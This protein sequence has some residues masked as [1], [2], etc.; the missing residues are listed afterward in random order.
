[1]T[2][3]EA[4]KCDYC[5]QVIK[6]KPLEQHIKEHHSKVFV[7]KEPADSYEPYKYRCSHLDTRTVGVSP[8][9]LTASQLQ[10]IIFGKEVLAGN[11]ALCANCFKVR[12]IYKLG[13]WP[14]LEKVE[15]YL[16]RW[17]RSLNGEEVKD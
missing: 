6:D 3:L 12:D 9:T 8:T 17:G 15:Q 14:A 16:R 2:T 7:P 10:S 4:V 1:M 11:V 13:G 5:K